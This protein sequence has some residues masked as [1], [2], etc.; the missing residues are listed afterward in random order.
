MAEKK[1]ANS[2]KNTLKKVLKYVGNYGIFMALSIIMA[3]VTVALTLYTPILIGD[4]I[5][6]IID[7]G[8]VDF[9]AISE[10]L[11]KIGIIVAVTGVFELP[12]NSKRPATRT[13]FGQWFRVQT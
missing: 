4:A 10:I 2:Q 6:F 8:N 11:I 9:E 13:I 1:S 12:T 3:A 5:D 7:K